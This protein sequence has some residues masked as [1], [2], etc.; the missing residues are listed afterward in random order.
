MRMR[1]A[2]LV[3]RDDGMGQRGN[4][5]IYLPKLSAVG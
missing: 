5:V 1:F 4:I 3:E 2:L